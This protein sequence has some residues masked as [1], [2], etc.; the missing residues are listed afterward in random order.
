[1]NLKFYAD[2]VYSFIYFKVKDGFLAD[3][4]RKLSWLYT[5]I[6]AI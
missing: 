4:C 5:K 1:M 3:L 2:T 6:T